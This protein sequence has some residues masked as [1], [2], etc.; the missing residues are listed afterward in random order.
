[1]CVFMRD[2]HTNV[3]D[4]L[5][6]GWLSSMPVIPKTE[7]HFR[8][9]VILKYS[10]HYSLQRR[11]KQGQRIR[12]VCQTERASFHLLTSPRMTHQISFITPNPPF[13]FT[14]SSLI[15]SELVCVCVYSYP[16]LV[17]NK[18]KGLSPMFLKSHHTFPLLVH[19]SFFPFWAALWPR[20]TAI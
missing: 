2:E 17:L 14:L 20:Y 6:D 3:N 13:L 10:H 19:S 12:C 1:M 18:E 5:L 9:L 4:P 8:A 16:P 11:K 7:L 15:C